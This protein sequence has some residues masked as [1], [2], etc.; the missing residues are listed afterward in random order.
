[1]DIPQPNLDNQPQEKEIQGPLFKES[2]RFT[3]WILWLILISL[4]VA[5]WFWF[6][7]LITGS[8]SST[9]VETSLT[10]A[11]VVIISWLTLG[12]LLPLFV[13]INKFELIV[14]NEEI[15]FRYVPY[16]MKY[17]RLPIKYIENYKIVRYDALGDYGGWGVRKRKRNVGYIT[18]SDR[19]IVVL[20]DG[21][22]HITFG[23]QM[24][25]EL[26]IA[27]DKVHKKIYPGKQTVVKNAS[28]VNVKRKSGKP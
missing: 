28:V 13:Y 26:Y 3:N 5:V 18:A 17:K 11:W 7:G 9:G 16:H 12:V 15:R 6:V 14:E 2:Q 1:M 4:A 8:A 20:V 27:I 10:P 24:P 25:K 21:A 22:T 23:T 19:G